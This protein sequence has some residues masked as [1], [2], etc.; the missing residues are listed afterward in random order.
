MC[1]TN[2][3]CFLGCE[4][5]CERHEEA[6]RTPGARAPD[7]RAAQACQHQLR[8]HETVL[9]LRR[10]AALPHRRASRSGP[11]LQDG[12]GPADRR[13]RGVCG[14]DSRRARVEARMPRSRVLPL[15][16]VRHAGGGAGRERHDPHRARGITVLYFQSNNS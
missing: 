3:V 5:V 16:P 2:P 13:G 1:E 7:I 14:A 11:H 12:G 6:G 8:G 15:L 9:R 10:G 4:R